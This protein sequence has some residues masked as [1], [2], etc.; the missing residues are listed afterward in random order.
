[1]F[2]WPKD[3]KSY[4]R[5]RGRARTLAIV[6]RSEWPG[7]SSWHSRGADL[8][9]AAPTC[10]NPQ[11]R[12]EEHADQSTEAENDQQT[13]LLWRNVEQRMEDICACA[14]ACACLQASSL[15][16]SWFICTMS[17]LTACSVGWAHGEG[18]CQWR[19]RSKPIKEHLYKHTCTQLDWETTMWSP[20]IRCCQ[21]LKIPRPLSMEQSVSGFETYCMSGQ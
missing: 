16:G 20:F 10:K 9:I 14:C 8:P 7:G 13:L 18:S 19:F 12:L 15:T 4:S 2:L 5:L 21:W 6:I 3:R 11:H 17:C 1:M